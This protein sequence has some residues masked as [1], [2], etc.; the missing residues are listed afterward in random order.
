MLGQ[1]VGSEW[2]TG[3]S[4]LRSDSQEVW[5]IGCD[6]EWR[7]FSDYVRIVRFRETM[8]PVEIINAREPLAVLAE[9][10][11]RGLDLNEG[12]VVKMNGRF[13]HGDECVHVLAL[14]DRKSTR[15]NSSH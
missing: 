15:L 13:Y 12:M 14:L 8:W 3:G 2:G 7:C 1:G 6:G 4:R 11:A 9:I 10:E 5:Q